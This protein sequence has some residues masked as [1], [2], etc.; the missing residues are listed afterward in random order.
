MGD[1]RHDHNAHS[2]YGSS[3]SLVE[4]NDRYEYSWN[5]MIE[6]FTMEEED[7]S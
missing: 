2:R 5:G 3:E 1:L 7:E 4:V 6:F